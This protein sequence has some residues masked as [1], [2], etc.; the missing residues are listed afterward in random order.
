[1]ALQPDISLH[2]TPP[3]QFDPIGSAQK[4]MTLRQLMTN[5]DYQQREKEQALASQAASQRAQ[6]ATTAGQLTLNE[7]AQR[8][9]DTKKRISKI[10]EFYSKTGNDGKKIIDYQS[11]LNHA[12]SEGYDIGTVHALAQEAAKTSQ[13]NIK[14]TSDLTD[15]AAKQGDWAMNLIRNAKTPEEAVAVAHS[16]K[17]AID[18]ASKHVGDQNLSKSLASRLFKL[19]DA[20]PMGP[21]GKPDLTAVAST[22][23]DTANMWA[24]SQITPLQAAE[25]KLQQEG[26]LQAGATGTGPEFRSPTS[27][28]SKAA[29]ATLMK[30]GVNVPINLSHAEM[31][32]NPTWKAILEAEAV[33][34]AARLGATA[35]AAGIKSTMSVIDSGL[36]TESKLKILGLTKLGSIAVEKW[37]RLIEENPELGKL[38][39]AIDIYN[40]NNKGAEISVSNN[41]LPVVLAR[42]RQFKA[43]SSIKKTSAEKIS[44]SPTLQEATVPTAEPAA[45]PEAPKPREFKEGQIIDGLPVYSAKKAQGLPKGT[46]FYGT[47]GKKYTTR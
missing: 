33:P 17:S 29:R 13:A 30:A 43:A 18:I 12:A 23:K 45:E 27:A 2:S 15:F 3:V 28:V 25:L 37:E 16:A 14:T 10:V 32:A 21:D 11:A 7:Q 39:S 44:T 35:E 4:A 9:L 36:A 5:V 47:N 41:G 22:L 19:P 6:E 31:M 34:S 38:Q 20:P 26:S 1:M 46:K 8:E 40:A 24:A 42:L